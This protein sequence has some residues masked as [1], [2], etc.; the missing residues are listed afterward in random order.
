MHDQPSIEQQ[1]IIDP[2]KGKINHNLVTTPESPFLGGPSTTTD[3]LLAAHRATI[4]DRLRKY[5][6]TDDFELISAA[7]AE[8]ATYIETRDQ[9]SPRHLERNPLKRIGKSAL[10]GVVTLVES[11]RSLSRREVDGVQRSANELRAMKA[12]PGIKARDINGT[13]NKPGYF[14]GIGIG[15]RTA[16]RGLNDKRADKISMRVDKAKARANGDYAF[17]DRSK[18]MLGTNA[19]KSILL[20]A[21][22]Q[23]KRAN[24]L[25]DRASKISPRT[26]PLASTGSRTPNRFYESFS[27][28]NYPNKKTGR[29]V[30]QAYGVDRYGKKHH[31][32]VLE[33]YGYDDVKQH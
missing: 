8:A 4:P 18:H 1:P 7:N 6:T 27:V 30:Y 21:A 24:K 17:Y 10:W 14:H 33:A 13:L 23:S 2:P 22:K 25:A 3:D 19:K 15:L 20:K 31:I 9:K 28:I 26:R 5:V 29:Q 16:Q 12:R 11:Y 32:P